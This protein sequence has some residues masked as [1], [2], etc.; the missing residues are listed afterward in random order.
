MSPRE[1]DAFEREEE[2]KLTFPFEN[3]SGKE[4]YSMESESSQ[5]RMMSIG[6]KKWVMLSNV[7]RSIRLM[8]QSTVKQI[9]NPVKRN[10]SYI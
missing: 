2:R 10:S 6:K 4:V 1:H 5:R 7:L 8:K 3:A 9:E